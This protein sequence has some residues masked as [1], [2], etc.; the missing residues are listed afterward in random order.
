MLLFG[1]WERYKRNSWTGEVVPLAFLFVCEVFGVLPFPDNRNCFP[2]A[3][4]VVLCRGVERFVRDGD[5]ASGWN[6]DEEVKGWSA[7]TP[8]LP[9]P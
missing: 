4:R 3:C 8:V 9:Q 6:G 1:Q 7:C 5:G 2:V